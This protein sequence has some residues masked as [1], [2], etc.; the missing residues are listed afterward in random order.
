MDNR[1]I[2]IIDDDPAIRED[3]QKILC[4]EKN[5]AFAIL[6]EMEKALFDSAARAQDS[7]PLFNLEF[8]SQGKEGYEI[9]QRANKNERPYAVAFIDIRMPPGWDGVET[10]ARIR[11]LDSNIEI[12]MVTAY[13]DRDR[14]SMIEAVTDASKLLYLKKPFDPDEI[15]QLAHSLTDKWN[16]GYREKEYRR[17]LEKMLKLFS[18]LQ[19]ESEN[20]MALLQ[21]ILTMITDFFGAKKSSLAFTNDKGS[22][23]EIRN[24]NDGTDSV[25]IKLAEQ[26]K[27]VLFTESGMLILPLHLVGGEGVIAIEIPPGQITPSNAVLLGG[28]V[29]QNIVNVVN[30]FHFQRQVIEKQS[31]SA[32]G[33][34]VYRIIHDINN[35]VGAIIGFAVLIENSRNINEKDLRR[36]RSI[37][38]AAENIRKLISTLYDL[39]SDDLHLLPVKID[40]RELLIE[41]SAEFQ[42]RFEKAG[43]DATMNFPDNPIFVVADKER[44]RRVIAE[45]L[46][47]SLDAV[48]RSR[49]DKKVEYGFSATPNCLKFWVKD[50]G[51]GIAEEHRDKVWLPF[52]T[53]GRKNRIGLGLALVKKLV[54]LSGGTVALKSELNSGTEVSLSIPI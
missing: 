48:E 2:L 18:S 53:V 7:L 21:E 35:P 23:F 28:I 5:A 32:V 29:T 38:T 41:I 12:V 51:V 3:Y 43:V 54:E 26:P 10:A 46:E 30:V 34:A 17:Y 40:V 8:A 14:N 19:V 52:Y 44:F 27:E 50:T 33:N 15:R 4:P 39:I 49:G 42:P 22:S 47:N 37:L 9:V 6:E 1:R 45:L 36:V 16:L 11:K 25:A 20:E 31:L 24:G 13:S